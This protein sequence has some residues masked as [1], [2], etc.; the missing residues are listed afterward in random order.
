MSHHTRGRKAEAKPVSGALISAPRPPKW[1]AK[2]ARTEWSRIMPGLIER[3]VLTGSDMAAVEMYC[4]AVGDVLI[5]RAAIAKA[6][7]YIANARGELKR[8]PAFSTLRESTGEARRWAAELGITPASRS[9]VAAGEDED[10][11]A[12]DL[13]F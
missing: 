6:G 2:E 11:V 1:L 9:R 3:R 8:H 7:A 5:A 4:A 10:S 12:T 13:D